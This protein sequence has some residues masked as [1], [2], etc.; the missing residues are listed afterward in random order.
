[1][2]N[3]GCMA[4]GSVAYPGT[5]AVVLVVGGLAPAGPKLAG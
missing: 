4:A 3:K 1:M 2:E 5:F